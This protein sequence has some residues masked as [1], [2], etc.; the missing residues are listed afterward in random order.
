[1]AVERWCA[2]VAAVTLAMAA[3]CG[4]DANDNSSGSGGGSVSALR[5]WCD[6]LADPYC[7]ALFACCTDPTRLIYADV[8][9]CKAAQRT[10]RDPTIT[11]L[12]ARDR[13]ELDEARLAECA[14]TLEGL[15]AGGTVCTESPGF[16]LAACRLAFRGKI[17]VGQSCDTANTTYNQIECE[18]GICTDGVCKAF[19]PTGAPCNLDHAPPDEVCNLPEG[20]W[21]ILEGPT[22]H[23]GPRLENGATCVPSPSSPGSLDE[24]CVSFRCEGGM[25]LPPG[26]TSLCI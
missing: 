26:D 3:A 2:G 16:V 7:E 11:D 12:L 8:E 22:G 15:A 9:A 25:C 24:Q 19:L 14:S 20:E 4:D 18:A 21:C 1:M 6:A 10:C 5:E 17:A 13:T 23:C